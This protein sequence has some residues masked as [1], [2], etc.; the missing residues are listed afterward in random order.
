MRRS[1]EI[2]EELVSEQKTI[3]MF[4]IAYLQFTASVH[5]AAV[6][7]CLQKGQPSQIVLLL[8]T[9]VHCH[10]IVVRVDHHL[11]AD[12]QQNGHVDQNAASQ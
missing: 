3:Q 2:N 12:V 10:V 1:S 8:G 11:A 4:T 5:V 9:A 6:F 7:R